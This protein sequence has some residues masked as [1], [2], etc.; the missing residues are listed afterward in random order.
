MGWQQWRQQEAKAR[1]QVA[2]L[3]GVQGLERCWK[4]VYL[5][6]LGRDEVHPQVLKEPGL[7]GQQVAVCNP[8]PGGCL[9]I[10]PFP[11]NRAYCQRWAEEGNRRSAGWTVPDQKPTMCWA[12]GHELAMP[13]H[14]PIRLVRS[15]DTPDTLGW[16]GA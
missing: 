2:I 8:W 1:Q 13:K 10:I 12:E 11:A 14:A 4:R 3:P 9:P 15:R 5:F 6:A 16:S 7:A